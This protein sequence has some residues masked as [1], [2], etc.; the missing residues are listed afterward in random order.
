MDF[1]MGFSYFYNSI[2]KNVYINLKPRIYPCFE[3]I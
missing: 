2:F 3:L 1:M